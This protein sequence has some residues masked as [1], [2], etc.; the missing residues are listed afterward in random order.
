VSASG[1]TR[2]SVEPS[3]PFLHPLPLPLP[4]SPCPLFPFPSLPSPSHPFLPLH[5]LHFPS[6][7][8]YFQL[9]PPLPFLPFPLM[10]A[11][12]LEQRYSSP[13]SAVPDA[14][15]IFFA[16]HSRQSGNLLN[17]G[18]MGSPRLCPPCPRR[19][20]ATGVGRAAVLMNGDSAVA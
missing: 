4:S 8:P 17:V 18:L 9:S 2:N 5:V 19:C 13:P 11:R 14:K 7:P 15:R 20:Y 16:I 3:L 1:V 6:A 10:T 12:G